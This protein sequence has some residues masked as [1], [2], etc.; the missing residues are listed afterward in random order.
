M[1]YLA[2]FAFG[3]AL[4]AASASALLGQVQQF[5]QANTTFLIESELTV[6]LDAAFDGL[7]AGG[8]S[9]HVGVSVRGQTIYARGQ[10]SEDLA[11]GLDLPIDILSMTKSLTGAAVARLLLEGRLRSD[12]Q[13]GEI[14]PDVPAT[15]AVITVH[16]LL[17]HSSGLPDVL[18][19]D[20][21]HL[22]RDAYLARAWTTPLSF[23]PGSRYGYSNVGYAVLAA[24]IERITHQS[25]EFYLRTA[26]LV[27]AGLNA[28][29]YAGVCCERPGTAEIT[30]TSWGGRQPS[31]HLIGAGGML[32]TPR[33]MLRWIDFYET[34]QLADGALLELTHQPY[35]REGEDAL[36]FYGYGLVIEEHPRFGRVYWHNGGSRAYNGHWRFYAD[37][38]TA[39]FI[40]SDQWNIDSD[41]VE[42]V[43]A[44]AMFDEETR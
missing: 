41:A 12:T 19:D 17:T 39:I 42:Q 37:H 15:K 22:S 20:H 8:F 7:V 43:I 1:K 30:S 11:Y 18:G 25:Y 33:D 3:I 28:T 29:G 26:L 32:S 2:W 5:R 21:E 23:E 38:R 4:Y 16:Q 36:T 44:S 34:G 24:I 6:R 31:W 35:Q 13:L 10:D 9:G 14:F 40:S 27:P